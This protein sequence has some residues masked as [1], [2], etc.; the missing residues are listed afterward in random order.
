MFGAIG[1]YFRALGYLLVGKVDPTGEGRAR[2]RF[3]VL[4]ETH[5]Y[6]KATVEAYENKFANLVELLPDAKAPDKVWEGI[7]SHIKASPPQEEKAPWWKANFFKQGFAM[8]AI[9]NALRK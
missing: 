8:M 9:K 4:M 3:E 2:K 1:R 5:F 7:E 6:L